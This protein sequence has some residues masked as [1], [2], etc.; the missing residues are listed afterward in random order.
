M[1]TSNCSTQ[2]NEMFAVAGIAS[3]TKTRPSTA[4]VLLLATDTQ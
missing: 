4:E 3:A 2:E 1:Q